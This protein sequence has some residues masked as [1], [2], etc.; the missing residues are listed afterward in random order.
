[1]KGTSWKLETLVDYHAIRRQKSKFLFTRTELNVV[2]RCRKKALGHCH[3]SAVK[4]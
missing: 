1:M 3:L 4:H 2:C